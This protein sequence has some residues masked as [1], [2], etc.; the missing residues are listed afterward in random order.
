MRASE[1]LPAAPDI[2]KPEVKT[3][4]LVQPNKCPTLQKQVKSRLYRKKIDG[5]SFRTKRKI[6]RQA[7][8]HCAYCGKH[9]SHTKATLDHILPFSKGGRYHQENL[10]LSCQACNNLKGNLTMEQF[11]RLYD[12]RHL[13]YFERKPSAPFILTISQQTHLTACV[14]IDLW[15]DSTVQYPA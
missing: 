2:K 15:K 14:P 3:S 4:S 9:V 1:P 12:S 10:R 6:Y 7:N 13:F 11:R 5:Y 8:G